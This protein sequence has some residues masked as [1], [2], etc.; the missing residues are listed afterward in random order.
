MLYNNIDD[1][2]KD[3]KDRLNTEMKRRNAPYGSVANLGNESFNRDINENDVIESEHSNKT[4]NRL[5]QISDYGNN[6]SYKDFQAGSN[7]DMLED[8][9]RMLSKMEAEDVY[10]GNSCRGLCS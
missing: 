6:I 2:I 1:Y 3:L 8:S 7:L 9:N 10:S 5:M 4:T